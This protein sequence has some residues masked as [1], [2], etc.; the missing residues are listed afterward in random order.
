MAFEVLTILALI[1]ANGLLAGAEIAVVSVRKSRLAA[2]LAEKRGGAR[3]LSSLRRNP[4]RFL[5]TV[6][7]GITVIGT[8][9]GAF[10]GATLARHLEPL[11]ARLPFAGQDAHDVSLV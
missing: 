5:A 6:Q 8:A 4:E 2:L 10:G 11:I 3:A 1:L 9:G 7:I